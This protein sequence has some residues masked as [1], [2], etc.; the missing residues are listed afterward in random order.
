MNEWLAPSPW[1]LV[2]LVGDFV[3]E[4][5]S[6]CDF[7]FSLSPPAKGVLGLFRSFSILKN[8]STSSLLCFVFFHQWGLSCSPSLP[9]FVPSPI[10]AKS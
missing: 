5:L 9:N 7:Y 2:S 3:P 6:S 4:E 10:L 1:T 8:I